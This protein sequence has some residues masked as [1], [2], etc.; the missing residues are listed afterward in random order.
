M[1]VRTPRVLGTPQ[2]W[3]DACLGLGTLRGEKLPLVLVVLLTLF[4]GDLVTVQPLALTI[5]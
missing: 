2:L 4:P 5:S 3:C 1:R